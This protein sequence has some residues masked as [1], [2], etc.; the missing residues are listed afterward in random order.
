MKQFSFFIFL[1]C[2]GSNLFG[3]EGDLLQI[4]IDSLN[5]VRAELSNSIRQ[6]DSELKALK[7]QKLQLELKTKKMFITNTDATLFK[8]AFPGGKVGIVPINTVLEISEKSGSYYKVNYNGLTGYIHY[9]SLVDIQKLE[10]QKEIAEAKA[11][12]ENVLAMKS[13]L[14]RKQR[15]IKKY[16]TINGARIADHKIWI[17]MTREML[18]ESL[19]KPNDINRTVTASETHEQF[20]YLDLYVYVENGIVTSYQD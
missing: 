8:G 1:L 18:I 5:K 7:L 17:G 6:I 3:Q 20:V 11:N 19:G 15:L 13:K 4:K 9:A 16:G 14:E 12:N 10:K 2:L